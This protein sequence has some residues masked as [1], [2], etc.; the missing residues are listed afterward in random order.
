VA[1]DRA[2]RI[3]KTDH[4]ND[5]R[6][7]GQ[8]S[9]IAVRRTLSSGAA[10]VTWRLVVQRSVVPPGGS[11]YDTIDCLAVAASPRRYAPSWRAGDVIACEGSLR[12]RF[13]R[14]GGATISRCEVEVTRAH[15]VRRTRMKPAAETEASQSESAESELAESESVEPSAQSE[16]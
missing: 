7:I 8:L 3:Q 15:V 4:R 16:S 1:D 2:P 14:S 12:R 10:A 6:I 9:D 11:S 5:V 13:W